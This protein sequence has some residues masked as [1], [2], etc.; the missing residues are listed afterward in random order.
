MSGES[1]ME[2]ELREIWGQLDMFNQRLRALEDATAS[3]LRVGPER[4][5]VAGQRDEGPVGPTDAEIL[6]R[7]RLLPESSGMP[8]AVCSACHIEGRPVGVGETGC[9]VCGRAW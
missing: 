6:G 7:F 9:T 2:R 1:S 5:A 3:T 8:P 4:P